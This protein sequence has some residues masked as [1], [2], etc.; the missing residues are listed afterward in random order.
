MDTA[1]QH[2]MW[3]S[4]LAFILAASGS[5]VGLGNIWR[6]PYLTS[7]NG[8]GAFVLV[9][10][11]C[12]LLIGLPIMA[13]E[14]LMGRE[15]RMSPI[16]AILKIARDG[17][18]SKNWAIIGWLGMLA[19]VLILSF[20]SVVAG[21]T[22]DYS[23]IYLA[24]IFGGEGIS[25]PK[26]TFDGLLANPI[27]LLFWHS[28]FM[29][30]TFAVVAKGVEKGLERAVKFLMPAL[31]ILLLILVG[32]GMT[33][34][35][36]GEAMS[37]LF[38]PDFSKITPSTILAALGQ[39]FFSMSLGMCGIM[40]YAAYLPKDM[41]IPN[42]T[43]TVAGMDTMVAL[44]AGLAI[45]PVVI[46]FGIAPGGGGPGLI[47]TSL[48]L[49]FADMTGGALYGFAFFMLLMFAAW[50]SSIS[51]LEPPTA[52]MVERM[53]W[54]RAK[55][56]GVATAVIWLVGILTILGLNVWSHVTLGGR[57]L[58][59]MIEFVASDLVL[60]I[61]GM[62][63]ALFAGWVLHRSVTQ[64]ELNTLPNWLYFTWLWLVR[65]V[66][67]ILVAAVLINIII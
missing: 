41:S 56:A 23:W 40:A 58:Q 2:G 42:V 20:Y 3:S 22:L 8:G 28:L 44:L 54:S 18:H 31:L 14:I 43:A 47:F 26:E 4:R 57:D 27:K 61:G 51:L 5:A 33:T 37:F 66:A 36:M 60:P 11:G 67:P 49:A 17:G 38:S 62:L 24:E 48:P 30:I 7:E 52:Y 39:A 25:N 63:I 64:G 50:T 15:G 59:G 46:A 53:G 55:A 65:V 19:A 6:F 32:Y 21:W 35:K 16:N 34:G 10:L 13:S 9:Y 12:I 29:L 1:S 45:F